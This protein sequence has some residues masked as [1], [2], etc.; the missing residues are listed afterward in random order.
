LA[1]VATIATV[2]PH[3]SAAGI[4]RYRH[5]DR[6]EDGRAALVLQSDRGMPRRTPSAQE[7]E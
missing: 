2:R 5:A 6:V 7:A 1:F 3:L 4:S